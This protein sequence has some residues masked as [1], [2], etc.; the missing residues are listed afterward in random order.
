M[1]AVGCHLR[2]VAGER[3]SRLAF[4]AVAG[5]VATITF[6]GLRPDARLT[7]SNMCLIAALGL[8]VSARLAGARV[9]APAPLWLLASVAAIVTSGVL[10]ELFP[11]GRPSRILLNPQTAAEVAVAEENTNWEGLARYSSALLIT[12][13]LIAAVATTRERVVLLLDLWLASAAVCC[14]I[15][16]LDSLGA[17]IGEALTGVD[18]SVR[19]PDEPDRQPGLSLSPVILAVASSLVLPVAVLRAVTAAGRRR[20]GYAAVV[21]LVALGI[22]AT[23]TRAGLVAGFAGVVLVLAVQPGLRRYAVAV[24]TVAVLAVAALAATGSGLVPGVDRLF[25]AESGGVSN[26]RHRLGFE[27]AFGDIADRPLVGWGF[28]YIRFAHNIYL[29]L[30]QAGG[31]LALGGFAL[32]AAGTLRLAARLRGDGRLSP[33]LQAVAAA[34]GV[35]M[36]VW[37]LVGLVQGQLYDRFLLMPTALLLGLAVAVREPRSA[38]SN[39]RAWRSAQ[40]RAP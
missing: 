20:I 34:L 2:L 23:G 30:L 18:N 21:V 27:Q 33:E 40:A 15:A 26:S 28:Q 12:P 17:G 35:A 38:S 6:T 7:V 3:L 5:A 22:L 31:P 25:G 8:L 39:V 37:L 14:A 11:P 9:T 32:F 24:A 13:V 19:L 4:L 1:R 10:V 29:Q 36:V 16:L